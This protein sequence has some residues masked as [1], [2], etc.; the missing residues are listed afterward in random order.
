M[1]P[2]VIIISGSINSG[3]T[4]TSKR[5]VE[6]RTKA[7]HVHG[8][9][10]RHFVTG[11]TLE[12]A[13]PI[14]YKNI[15]SVAQNFLKDGYDVVIDYPFYK[16]D[17]NSLV[18][19]LSKYAESIHAFI[20]SP[21]LAVAQSQRGERVLSQQEVDRIAYHYQTNLH[22]P[23]FGIAIDNSELTLEKTVELILT[24]V[25]AIRN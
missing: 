11:Q 1:K 25:D 23:D 4:T 2:K 24:Y 21:A 3:K 12:A 22:N 17:F 15:S 19:H 14:T 13:I 18:V 9:S 6:S 20:L 16:K 8:D 10:L 5:L 7:A